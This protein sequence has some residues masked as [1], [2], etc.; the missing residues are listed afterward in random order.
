MNRRTFVLSLASAAFVG[1]SALSSSPVF[2]AG[3]S[4]SFSGHKNYK[5]R[6]S[7]KVEEAGGKTTV[8]LSGFSTTRG[9]DLYIYVGNGSPTKLIAKLKKTSGSQS[10]TLPA[11]MTAASF[12]SVHVH[13]K[14]YSVVFGTAKVR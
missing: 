11:G 10:Y 9:P 1:A 8:K 4:G 7:V 3:K 6:G 5:V 2:A 13:C 12:S 14:R